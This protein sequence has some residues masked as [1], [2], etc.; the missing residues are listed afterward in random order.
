LCEVG[1]TNVQKGGIETEGKNARKGIERKKQ[2][3]KE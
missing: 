3:N 2:T 1:S